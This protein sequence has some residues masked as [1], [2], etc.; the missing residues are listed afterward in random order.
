MNHYTRPQK[1]KGRDF[2]VNKLLQWV[3]WRRNV[4]FLLIIISI[5]LVISNLPR[6]SLTRSPT[7]YLTARAIMPWCHSVFFS[8]YL[9]SA[10][11]V[12]D[13]CPTPWWLQC[14]YHGLLVNILMWLLLFFLAQIRSTVACHLGLFT[15]IKRRELWTIKTTSVAD[16]PVV[17][18]ILVHDATVVVINDRC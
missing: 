6:N 12:W 1:F 17:P 16:I 18:L 11:F 13:Q 5:F 3:V 7:I 14:T 4:E 10:A 15:A 9:Q 2:L 8:D